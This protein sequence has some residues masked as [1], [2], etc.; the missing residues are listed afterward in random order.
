MYL[1]IKNLIKILF[2]RIARNLYIWFLFFINFYSTGLASQFPYSSTE[3]IMLISISFII[4]AS[5]M[6]INNLWL[7]PK[8]LKNKFYGA[9]FFRLI[10]LVFTF[11]FIITNYNY[12]FDKFYPESEFD[13]VTMLSLGTNDLYKNGTTSFIELFELACLTTIPLL[14]FIFLFSL[15]W[16]MNDYFVQQKRLD[17]AIKEKLESEL[18]LI[19]NQI[20]PHFLF[21]TLNNLY[22]LS[23]VKSDKLSPSILQLANILRYLI[24][25]SN[26]SLMPFVKEK[27]IVESLINLELLRLP[28]I[29]NLNFTIK[30]DKNYDIPPLLWLPVLENIFK[31]GTRQINNENNVDFRFEIEKNVLFIHSTNNFEN[32]VKNIGDTGGFGIDNLKKRL[33][34]L[35]PKNYELVE[36]FEQ[37]IYR[38]SIKIKLN[39]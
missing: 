16:F 18:A 12:L 34:I 6:Y 26:S 1:F 32:S 36:T 4:Y 11:S 9:Y 20:N 37:N 19:K 5:M 29:K 31:H 23:L 21:N 13:H 24:Y 33:N 17:D 2:G 22:G 8:Y 7:L 27:E 3:Y 14:F 28:N 35:F 38:I 39:E 25:E 15:G 10:F 30:S